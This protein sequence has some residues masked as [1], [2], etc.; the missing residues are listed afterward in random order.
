MYRREHTCRRS[1]RAK[2]STAPV[3]EQVSGDG[4]GECAAKVTSSDERGRQGS[5]TAGAAQ[6][7]HLPALRVGRETLMRHR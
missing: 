3:F 7:E 5:E 6:Y 2:R 4:V 1:L